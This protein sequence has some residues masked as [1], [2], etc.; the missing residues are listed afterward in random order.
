MEKAEIFNRIKEMIAEQFGIDE[1]KITEK[2][3]FIDDL[4]ADSLDLVE[5]VMQIEENFDIQ[6]PDEAAEKM[7]TVEDMVTYIIENK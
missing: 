2:S 3:A 5:L 4:A 7:K 6:I 1:E